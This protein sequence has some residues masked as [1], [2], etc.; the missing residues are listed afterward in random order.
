MDQGQIPFDA[1]QI[2]VPIQTANDK[3]GVEV[4]GENPFSPRRGD[5][6]STTAGCPPGQYVFPLQ[7]FMDDRIGYQ[8][9]ISDNGVGTVGLLEFSC[10][11]GKPFRLPIADRKTVL[12]D[13]DHPRR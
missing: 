5:Q 4:G 13:P 8:H 12:V 3:N 9:P 11:R 1:A 10:G 2:V 7:D 6:L